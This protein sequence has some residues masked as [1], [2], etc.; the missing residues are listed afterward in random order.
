MI[1]PSPR[2]RRQPKGA[3]VVIVA[4]F[5][6]AIIAMLAL[7]I[8]CGILL[9]QRANLQRAADAA[10]LAGVRDL[11][12]DSDG[13]Q[14]FVAVRDAVKEY[15]ANNVKDIDN[16]T[17][18]DADI[19][20]GRYDPETIYS[21]LTILNTGVFDTVRVTLRRDDSANS[22]VTLFFAGIFGI[23]DS[24]VTATAAAVL[25]KASIMEPGAGVLPF[26][27]PQNEW[28]ASDPGATWSIYGDGKLQDGNGNNVPGN[29]GTC[30]I[31][32]ESNSTADLSNQILDG[33]RQ[34]DLDA[35]YGAGRI[36]QNTY[37]DGSQSCYMN[38]ETGLSAGM[39]A[40][41]QAVYGQ[42]RLIPLIDS[43]S[44]QGGNLE[45]HVVGWA[46]CKVGD[47]SFTGQ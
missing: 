28:H 31:G 43:F 22:P 27:V 26:T 12:P 47:S 4:I 10:A 14:D 16:F 15:A 23:L 3:I 34:T 42:R 8:D 1:H 9:R 7:A 17:V 6:P 11:I 5:L 39:K 24:D 35:L 32:I 13:N 45:Y 25:Q 30:D 36:P 29:W 41:V 2:K 44:N 40:A 20:I 38:G 18:L 21:E 46:V 37:I 19:E 33:L